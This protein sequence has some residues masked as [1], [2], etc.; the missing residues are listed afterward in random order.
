MPVTLQRDPCPEYWI[1]FLSLVLET[2]SLAFG[3]FAS[4]DKWTEQQIA[5][6]LSSIPTTVFFVPLSMV[7][8]TSYTFLLHKD[9]SQGDGTRLCKIG[10]R[11]PLDLKQCS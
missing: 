3:C 2:L 6:L 11:T 8:G 9:A 4:F 1:F 5:K 7:K 10:T